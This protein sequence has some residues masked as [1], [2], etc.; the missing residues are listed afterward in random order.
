MIA[1]FDKSSLLHGLNTSVSQVPDEK[2]HKYWICPSVLFCGVS[3]KYEKLASFS[4]IY[5]L[6][7]S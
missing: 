7:H 6:L 5:S 3:S 2:L 4:D 1:L